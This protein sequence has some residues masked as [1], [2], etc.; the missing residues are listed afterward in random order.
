MGCK[1]VACFLKKWARQFAGPSGDHRQLQG[2][3]QKNYLA[4]YVNVFCRRWKYHQSCIYTICLSPYASRLIQH[5]K[6]LPS[7]YM[8]MPYSTFDYIHHSPSLIGLIIMLPK[9][10]CMC[11][12]FMK[13]SLEGFSMFPI[14]DEKLSS[15]QLNNNLLYHLLPHVA[16]VSCYGCIQTFDQLYGHWVLG[17]EPVWTARVLPRLLEDKMTCAK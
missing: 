11:T 7:A 2:R 12:N 13:A 17:S 1:Q 6:D 10:K 15:Q 16:R 5:P 4:C 3:K 14:E 9:S 8:E